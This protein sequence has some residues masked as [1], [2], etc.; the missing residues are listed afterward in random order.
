MLHRYHSIELFLEGSQSKIYTA[1]DRI[2]ENRCIVKAGQSVHSEA[3]LALELNHPYIAA[4]YDLGTDPKFGAFAVYEEINDPPVA[5]IWNSGKSRYLALQFAEFLSYLHHCGWLYNDFKPEHFLGDQN[6]I[7]VID[8]GLC[9][10]IDKESHSKSQTFSGTFPYI[11]PERLL[12]RDVD[13]RSDIFA[14]G[15]LFLRMFLPD[16]NWDLPHSIVSLQELQRRSRKLKGFWG[17]LIFQMMSL[18]PSQRPSSAEELW[19]RLLPSSCKRSFL[20]FPVPGAMTVS[21]QSLN[22]NRALIIHSESRLNLEYIQNRQMIHAWKHDWRT[23][24][25]NFRKVNVYDAVRSLCEVAGCR[26]PHDFYDALNILQTLDADHKTLIFLCNSEALDSEQ[27]SMLWF[28]ISTLPVSRNFRVV[29]LTTESLKR[30]MNVDWEYV[31]VPGFSREILQ[32]NIQKIFPEHSEKL[33]Q[34]QNEMFA[35]PEQIVSFLQDE[36]KHCEVQAWPVPAFQASQIVTFEELTVFEKRILAGLAVAGS[37]LGIKQLT[38]LNRSGPE[39]FL[40]LIQTLTLKGYIAESQ[41]KYHLTVPPKM[42]LRRFRRHQIKEVALAI[43][44]GLPKD[45]LNSIYC[46]AKKALKNRIAARSALLAAKRELHSTSISAAKGWFWKAFA[47]GARLPKSI[48]YRLATA[49]TRHSEMKRAQDILSHIQ[50]RFGRSFRLIDLSIDLFHRKNDLNNASALSTKAVQIARKKKNKLAE[51]YFSIRL[52][53]F[54]ILRK[55]LKKGERILT[56]L[57]KQ[58]S[59]SQ[60]S[61]LIHHFLGLTKLYRGQLHGAIIDFNKAVSTKHPFRSSSLMNLAVAYGQLRE[62]KKAERYLRHAIK[63]FSRTEDTDR[64]SYAYNNLGILLKEKGKFKESQQSH[65]CSIHLSRAIGNDF[66]LSAAYEN[67]AITYALEGRMHLA[68]SCGKIA[69]NVARA[70]GLDERLAGVL[71]NCGFHFAIT[72]DQKKAISW[73]RKLLRFEKNWASE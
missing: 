23:V 14:L 31:E 52:A 5:K 18:E 8:L 24:E 37:A 54:C 32:E 50:T 49:F 70:A 10:P 64:L 9:S 43:L 66:I 34:L 72:G 69:A 48:L 17:R 26:K 62:F 47:L 2:K 13:E 44:P 39:S 16:E 61:G 57:E 3:L 65:W 68:I 46:T 20:F 60:H 58:S 33:E 41:G 4:P 15:V 67:L 1:I 22:N 63:R 53:G 11:S 56:E 19:Q 35:F 25:F 6:R 51:Q 27:K 38:S 45:D 21:E 71:T 59:Q 28:L 29:L 40:A 12:G 42:V 36:L 55:Q 30:E 7:R 73:L